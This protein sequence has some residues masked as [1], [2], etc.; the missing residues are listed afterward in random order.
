MRTYE[1]KTNRGTVSSDVIKRVVS[2]VTDE[3]RPIRAVA[4]ELNICHVT[5]FRY[6]RKKRQT[7]RDPDRT[8]YIPNRQI[9]NEEQ[10]AIL[11]AYLKK[12]A[13]IYFGLTPADVRKLA[14]DCALHHRIQVPATWTTNERAEAE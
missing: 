7:G 3:N 8:G 14:Y 1:R 4:R 2:L 10:E 9:F 5:L 13:S 11:C 12:C 6:V